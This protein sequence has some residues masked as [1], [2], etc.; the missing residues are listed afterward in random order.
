[1]SSPFSRSSWVAAACAA[2]TV[3]AALAPATPA[4]AEF[5]KPE[6]MSGTARLLFDNAA[7]PALSEDASHVAFQ[8]SLGEVPGVY[9]RDIASGHVELV[10]G[11]DASAPSISTDGRY[12]A[13]TSTAVLTAAAKPGAGC[14]QVY[15]R[16]MDREP[17]PVA[18]LEEPS[19]PAGEEP[20]P[21]NAAYVL[22]SALDGQHTGLSYSSCPQDG[23]RTTPAVALSEDGQW[24]VF[25]VSS[26]NL[27]PGVEGSQIAVRDLE[28]DATS[29][30]STTPTGA[31]TPGGGA[32][33]GVTA[34]ISADG[35]AVAWYG[36][37]VPAQVPSAAAEIE[38]GMSRYGGP[39][40]EDEPL[41]RRL[42][43]GSVTR[44]LL[45]GS[46]FEFYAYTYQGGE[47]VFPVMG[48]ALGGTNGLAPVMLSGDGDTA[49]T[50]ADVPTPLNMPT[51]FGR[52]LVGFPTPPT[53][54]YAIHISD[55]PSVA[56]QVTPLTATPNFL[57]PR[58]FTE[59]NIES[60]SISPDGS[61]VAFGTQRPSFALASPTL[62]SP[63]APEGDHT[64]EVNL[65]LDTLQRIISGYEGS[66]PNGGVGQVSFS[67]DGLSLAFATGAT[68]LFYGDAGGGSEVYLVHE[69]PSTAR[70]AEQ[71]IQPAPQSPSPAPE[72]LLSA[73]ATAQAD[74]SAIVEAAVPGAG[75]LAA[76]AAAQLT[77]TA[78][79]STGA[80]GRR[81]VRAKRA[82][83]ARTLSGLAG[84]DRARG[85]AR[86]VPLRTLGSA[87]AVA[88][89]P[90]NIRLRLRVG[91]RYRALLDRRGGLYCLLRVTFVAP[92][93]ATLIREIP[94]TLRLT[95]HRAVN[96]PARRK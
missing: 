57:A 58:V 42:G 63:P 49:V 32:E 76:G 93:H 91:A 45:A 79:R 36:T 64:Y 70:P 66:P 35:S 77:G 12:V 37:N 47:T 62:I 86:T 18:E 25:T 38:A 88:E 48:G 43:P 52:L 27:T 72:W 56:P 67:A 81:R 41:W 78:R 59:T 50:L 30:V 68:N 74:G 9:L 8:G 21:A 23:S 96:R 95:A 69:S 29:V 6:L 73:T 10:A 54:L 13:F 14:P 89:G 15:V 87:A 34:S 4:R 31:P 33:P 82:S 60:A 71:S 85:S 24:V 11:G 20:W 3:A 7:E 40:L 65:Q 53:D 39:S 1:M 28:T 80:T 19:R 92:G 94:L 84:G 17:D 75:R 44:R 51:Y 26:S 90:S 16:D 22:A 83:A 46:G 2:A 61:R 55:D 5:G